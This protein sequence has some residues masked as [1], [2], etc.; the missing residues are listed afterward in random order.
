MNKILKTIGLAAVA[1]MVLMSSSVEADAETTREHR[2]IWCTPFLSHWPTA[3]ISAGNAET[4]KNVL[5]KRMASYKEQGINVIYYHVRSECDATYKSSYEPWAESVS[6]N[7]GVAPAFDPF[8]FMVQTCHEYGIECYA[9][10]NPYRYHTDKN[11]SH[12]PTSASQEW[13]S[14][15]IDYENSHPEW[16]MSGT[17]NNTV[18][19]PAKAEVLQRILDVT[20][21]IVTNYDIDGVIFDDYFYPQGGTAETSAAPDYADYVASGT[22]L[23]MGDWRRANVNNM[24]GEVNKLIKSLKPYVCFGIS[25]AGKS[26]PPNVETEYGMPALGGDFQYATIYSDPLHWLKY[27]QLDFVSPQVYWVSEFKK[28]SEWWIDAA[29]KFDRHMYVSTSPL[30]YNNDQKYAGAQAMIDEVNMTREFNRQDETGLVYFEYKTFNNSSEK[31]DGTNRQDLGDILYQYAYQNK[32]LTPLRHWNNVRDPKITS[33]V[34]VSGTTLTWDEVEGMRYTVYAVPTTLSESEFSCQKQYLEQVCY[35]NSYTIPDAKASG[36]NWAVCVYDRYGNEYAP[37]FAGKTV[38]TAATPTLTFPVNGE[39]APDLFT[40]TWNA[41]GTHYRVEMAKDAAFTQFVGDAETDE[42]KVSVTALEATIEAGETYY[43]RVISKKPNALDKTSAVGS[44]VASRIAITSPVTASTDV[45]LT[46]TISWTP[47]D[48]CEFTMEISKTNAFDDVVYSVTTTKSS[49]VVPERELSSYN[50]YY[51]RVIASKDG[52]SSISDVVTFKTLEITEF[53]V[54]E[55]L[56]PLTSGIIV[57]SN[58]PIELK[59]YTGLTSV[60][61]DISKSASFGRGKVSY[62]LTNLDCATKP[63][64]EI[65]IS[66]A[67]LVDGT[68]YYVRA[69]GSYKTASGTKN[70][71]Y[72]EVISFVYNAGAGVEGVA[73]DEAKVYVSNEN[74]V[75]LGVAQSVEIYNIGGQLVEQADV[76]GQSTFDINHLASGAYIIKVISANGVVT[77]KHVK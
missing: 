33:N 43:W 40:F 11:G 7:R 63:A 76:E 39:K 23:S 45:S 38:G 46:P 61:V 48:G 28:R 65:T 60:V 75:V 14:K 44:F 13:V 1:S 3:S 51:V 72:T 50:D 52:V 54:P 73:N 36:Y 55:F 56:R 58:Q 8:E 17:S 32:A 25:P 66:S 41:D 18:L 69:R 35:T 29:I 9:W 49:V 59:P 62:T 12:K 19:N 15:E 47:I 34:T 42:A 26:S 37:L 2:A 77:L 74:V 24:V 10:I 27:Q 31:Y 68:T 6:G 53:A 22:T 5:R 57:Y 20:K 4:H 21:E 71:D 64:G 67:N 70:T 16:L 30:D